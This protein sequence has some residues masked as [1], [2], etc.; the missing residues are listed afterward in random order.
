MDLLYPYFIVST[1]TKDV[2][3]LSGTAFVCS[4]L[5]RLG[6]LYILTGRITVQ[7]ALG[8]VFH[9]LPSRKAGEACNYEMQHLHILQPA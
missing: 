2:L 1:N 7:L 9:S 4:E 3:A 5:T 8:P 6:G